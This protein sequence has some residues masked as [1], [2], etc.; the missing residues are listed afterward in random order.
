M[1]SSSWAVAKTH[2]WMYLTDHVRL[3]FWLDAD[4][5]S[6]GRAEETKQVA[7]MQSHLL[8]SDE[9][10]ISFFFWWVC[11]SSFFEN[12]FCVHIHKLHLF[13][14]LTSN[15]IL[16]SHAA[17]WRVN[18]YCCT[19]EVLARISVMWISLMQTWWL[20]NKVIWLPRL[21]LS[22]KGFVSRTWT[23]VVLGLMLPLVG[24]CLDERTGTESY[25]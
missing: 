10:Q 20:Y 23:C 5:Q 24:L 6:L 1:T 22:K 25:I 21:L 17:N 11:F 15:S 3:V 8:L 12:V 7:L 14:S 13:P 18:N 19:E 9:E 2:N 4:N 16:A